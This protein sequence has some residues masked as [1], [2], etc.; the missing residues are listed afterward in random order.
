MIKRGHGEGTIYEDKLRGLW[1]CERTYSDRETG[2]TKRKKFAAKSRKMAVVK[3]KKFIQDIESGLLA[4]ASKV[5]VGD[6]V[7]RWLN[8]YVKI[9][10]RPRTWEK[11]KSCLEC[12]ILPRFKDTLL[13]NLKAPDVQRHFNRLLEK[14][15]QDGEKLSSST[16]RGTRRYFTMCIDGA[17]KAGLLTHNVVKQ[18]EPP[19][20]VKK[21]IMVLEPEQAENLISRAKIIKS[22]FMKK[23]MPM[24]LQLAL[25]TGMRQGELF[26]LKWTDI[27]FNVGC[28]Y[29]KRSLAYVSGRGFILQDPKTKSSRRKIPVM[30]DDVAALLQYQAW[31]DSYKD[32]LGDKYLSHEL[33]FSNMFGGPLDT[34][35]FVSRYFKPLLKEVGI[36][37]GFTFHDLRH[38][39]ATILLREGVNPKIVQERL[40]HSTVTLTLDL[41]SHVLPD[42]QG[43][44]VEALEKAFANDKTASSKKDNM[45]NKSTEF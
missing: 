26:G 19:K 30:Q 5:T 39:H 45:S 20:L 43:V 44:A 4:E 28:I 15:R 41:Y 21:E 11:Y 31:Q 32:E 22:P 33:V 40:G 34:G 42:M 36:K 38:T 37:D 35:N 25:H 16:V 7:Y 14:G 6:W 9:R 17:I 3:A 18:T 2:K 29:V 1:I 10:V 24:V 8:D 12:Y 27:D 13:K 23:I